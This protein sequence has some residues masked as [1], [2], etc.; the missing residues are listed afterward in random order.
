MKIYKYNVPL[1]P[2]GLFFDGLGTSR[3]FEAQAPVRVGIL[4]GQL[5]AGQ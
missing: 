2:G 5:V 3:I 1:H 4:L